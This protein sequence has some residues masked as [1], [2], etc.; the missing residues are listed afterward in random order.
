MIQKKAVDAAHPVVVKV[1]NDGDTKG[2][3]RGIN[4]GRQTW[5]YV[6]NQPAIKFSQRLIL[7]EALGHGKVSE[8][9][10]RE[11]NP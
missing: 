5:Q 9:P 2:K 10:E 6:M 1:V 3:C 8:S 7:F 4:D 11:Q